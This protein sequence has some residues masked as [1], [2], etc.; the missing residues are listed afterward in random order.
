MCDDSNN[1][2]Q[3]GHGN[4]DDSKIA[5]RMQTRGYIRHCRGNADSENWTSHVQPMLSGQRGC[6]SSS[7]E[8][9]TI[10]PPQ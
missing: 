8:E 1:L 4:E 9:A 2:V 3:T 6:G 7:P 5:L 10:D